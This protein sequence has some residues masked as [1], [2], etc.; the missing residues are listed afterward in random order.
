MSA[1][2]RVE[3]LIDRRMNE[4]ELRIAI[5]DVVRTV[6]PFDH[7]VWLLTDP[8]SCVGCMPL[9]DVPDLREIPTLIRLRY[10]HS[11]N[12]WSDPV[13]RTV[14]TLASA[15]VHG[16]PQ[17]PW[18]E[19]L[20][21]HRVSDVITTI[22]RDQFGCWGFID[23]W[24]EDGSVFSPIAGERLTELA[25]PI[26]AAVRRSLLATFEPVTAPLDH[27][28]PAIVLLDDDLRL[29]TQTAQADAYLRA[30]LPGPGPPVPA[31]V[32]NVGAQLLTRERKIDINPAQARLPLAGRWVTVRAARTE[33]APGAASV[34]AVSIEPATPAERTDVYARSAGLTHRETQLLELLVNGADTRAVAGQMFISQHTVQDH[35]KSIFAKCGLQTR[36]AVIA[37]ATGAA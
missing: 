13:S 22:L 18:C 28:E 2:E 35:L 4:R 36:K 11:E 3:S 7:Y 34:I 1:S 10:L 33:P 16:A 15:A 14:S 19:H 21:T 8:D 6:V 37:R 9:A 24:R 29:V 30:L 31:V 25:A 23:L 17:S 12:R 20:A 32:Y 27:H 26:T 5:L